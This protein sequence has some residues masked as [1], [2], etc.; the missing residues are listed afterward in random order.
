MFKWTVYYQLI[1]GGK[2]V[3]RNHHVRA[4]TYDGATKKWDKE[5]GG[6]WCFTCRGWRL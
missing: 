6:F 3:A 4:W 5:V 2:L 1:L